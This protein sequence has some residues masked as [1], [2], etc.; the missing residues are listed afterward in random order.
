M[1]ALQLL[2]TYNPVMNQLFDSTPLGASD[3]A[4]VLAVGLATYGI[5]GTEKWIRRR[6]FA[7]D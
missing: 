2:Y 7:R 5:V 1:T 3:W 4:L 6:W